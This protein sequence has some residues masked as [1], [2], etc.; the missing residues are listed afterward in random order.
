MNN[1]ARWK[2]LFVPLPLGTF[3][4]SIFTTCGS[5][6]FVGAIGQRSCPKHRYT[7]E[8]A[9]SI[10]Y[11]VP[12]FHVRCLARKP[13][14]QWLLHVG[15]GCGAIRNWLN[16]RLYILNGRLVLEAGYAA[17][18][19]KKFADTFMDDDLDNAQT[20]QLVSESKQ[21]PY[22]YSFPENHR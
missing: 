8:G 14:E 13:W 16:K 19:M 17:M 15:D 3:D 7:L 9:R 11:R 5:W 18:K 1:L 4:N 6:T 22:K 12:P 21:Y 20:K 2:W 10:E